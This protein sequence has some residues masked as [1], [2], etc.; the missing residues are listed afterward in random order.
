MAKIYAITIHELESLLGS[1]VTTTRY[2]CCSITDLGRYLAK[3]AN[4]NEV[5]LQGVELGQVGPVTVKN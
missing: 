1:S 5:V 4:G 3:S 2:W